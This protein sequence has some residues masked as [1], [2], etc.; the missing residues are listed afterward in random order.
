MLLF[1]SG[2]VVVMYKIFH[3][4]SSAN[5]VGTVYSSG[6]FRSKECYEAKS[7]IDSIFAGEG[8]LK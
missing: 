3:I 2:K 6:A 5:L 1:M 7:E 8:K 4:I